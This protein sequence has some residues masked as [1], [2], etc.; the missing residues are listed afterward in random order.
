MRI[1]DEWEVIILKTGQPS[2]SCSALQTTHNQYNR[3]QSRPNILNASLQSAPVG[4]V[5]ETL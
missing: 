2:L 3:M 5:G 4:K 1:T